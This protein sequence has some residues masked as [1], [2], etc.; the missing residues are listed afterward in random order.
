MH[1]KISTVVESN[2]LKVKE[3][4]DEELFLKLNPPFPPVKLTKFDGCIKGGQ[5]ILELNFIL[6]KQRWVSDI[7]YDHTDEKIFE[8]IDEGVEL[9]FFLKEWKHHHIVNR[10]DSKKSQIVDD[11][12]FKA[13]FWI[14][15]LL[16]Y[17]A[18]YLQFLYRKPIY[19]KLF[20]NK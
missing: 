19:K 20:K 6:F 10:I 13:P 17:P 11:I 5:V 16:L 2:H 3:G 15:S 4:F 12:N 7:T 8:F 1:L 18:L 9:P 14:M